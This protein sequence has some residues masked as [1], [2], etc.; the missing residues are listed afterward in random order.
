VSET[1]ERIYIQLG[2]AALYDDRYENPGVKF[3]DADLIGI[4]D[5]LI[6][7]LKGLDRNVVEY[8]RRGG[9][10]EEIPLDNFMEIYQKI[11]EVEK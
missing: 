5:R 6:I 2:E 4:P 9:K 10:K 1:A 3:R 8:E 11:K 7:G